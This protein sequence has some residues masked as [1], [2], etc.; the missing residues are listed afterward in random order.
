MASKVTSARLRM[1]SKDAADLIVR[2]RELCKRKDVLFSS[3]DGA[4]ELISKL[5][6]KPLDLTDFKVDQLKN[7]CR[8]EGLHV[9]GNH[10]DLVRRL[11]ESDG[12]QGPARKKAKVD[13]A[14]PAVSSTMFS[15]CCR[16][17][18]VSFMSLTALNSRQTRA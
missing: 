6:Q 18:V 13:G 11:I 14:A 16:S 9:G 1:L 7:I 8:E 2:L 10:A 12:T 17:F 3:T 5:L 4:D 15:I